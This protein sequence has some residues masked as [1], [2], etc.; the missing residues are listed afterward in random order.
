MK[1]AKNLPL[2]SIL[3]LTVSVSEAAARS[4]RGIRIVCP[5][6]PVTIYLNGEKVSPLTNSC[7]VA[8]LKAGDYRIEAFDGYGDNKRDGNPVFSE[9]VH[10]LGREVTEVY[11]GNSRKKPSARMKNVPAINRAQFDRLLKMVKDE[12]FDSNKN[13]LLS[14]VVKKNGFTT[15]QIR[16]IVKQYDFDN[17]K[18][19]AL[20]MCY[21]SAVDPENYFTLLSML[22]FSS[23]KNEL[24]RFIDRQ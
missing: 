18:V 11:I 20:K 5:E 17:A 22:N 9:T 7:F 2:L 24:K 6:A 19:E 1:I 10:H 13:T 8:N 23:G 14:M 21:P 16:R 3:L 15:D 12:D 4:L